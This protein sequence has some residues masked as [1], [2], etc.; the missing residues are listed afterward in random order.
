VRGHP[1]SRGGV[2]PRD[3]G[4]DTRGGASTR[5]ISY[6]VATRGDITADAGVFDRARSTGLRLSPG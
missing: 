3:D 6:E 2:G 4:S 1:G 5:T